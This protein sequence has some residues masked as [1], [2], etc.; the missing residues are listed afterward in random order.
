MLIYQTIMTERD[1]AAGGEQPE[2]SAMTWG[3]LAAYDS[4]G[5]AGLVYLGIQGTH[6]LRTRPGRSAR[7][8]VRAAETIVYDAAQE[9]IG[10][11]L[12]EVAALI[13]TVAPQVLEEHQRYNID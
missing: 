10:Q 1:S 4:S 5:M 13:D 6:R 7:A 2:P 9:A 11:T 3:E 12:G 8:V